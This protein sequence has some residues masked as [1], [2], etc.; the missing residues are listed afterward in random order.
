MPGIDHPEATV[1]ENGGEA[2][3]ATGPGGLYSKAHKVVETF[4]DQ[5]P[6][7]PPIDVVGA[8]EEL[9]PHLQQ[10]VVRTGPNAVEALT[11][12]GRI[13]V[14]AGE[15]T[16]PEA[17]H[18]TL[19]EEAIG[20]YGV[21]QVLGEKFNPLADVVAKSMA[22]HPD[23]ER[24]KRYTART[25]ALWLRSILPVSRAMRSSLLGSGPMLKRGLT[26]SPDAS[27]LLASSV[28]RSFACFYR[29]RDNG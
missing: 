27:G 23:Y 15:N 25:C 19:L 26:S 6:H 29:V 8:R 16:S 12:E 18:R 9:P 22:G 24:L 2:G 11:H 5:F 4:K 28:M 10:M 20:H 7:A 1:H 21:E 17:L 3:T 13:H 14:V